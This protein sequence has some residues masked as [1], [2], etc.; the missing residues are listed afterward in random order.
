MIAVATA[1]FFSIIA[2]IVCVTL[3]DS[4]VRFYNAAKTIYPVT[5]PQQVD[6][7]LSRI[8]AREQQLRTSPS[9]HTKHSTSVRRFVPRADRPTAHS[10]AA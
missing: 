7:S 5:L 2:L 3:L 8:P 10:A 1:G 6:R 9:G 4:V